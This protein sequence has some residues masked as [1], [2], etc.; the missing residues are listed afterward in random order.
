MRLA[1]EQQ[2]R[3]A[4]EQRVAEEEAREAE[5]MRVAAESKVNEAEQARLAEEKKIKDARQAL[6]DAREEEFT[7]EVLQPGLNG[8]E[9]AEVSRSATQL[10]SDENFP[11]LKD[12]MESMGKRFST[13]KNLHD[14]SAKILANT[15]YTGSL[16][17]K[18][19]AI[20][21]NKTFS[22]NDGNLQMSLGQGKAQIKWSQLHPDSYV[23]LLQ[24]SAGNMNGKMKTS[25]ERIIESLQKDF[26]GA[27]VN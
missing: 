27:R 3:E 6:V 7:K 10:S 9:F 18:T 25:A 19:V 26:A 12:K 16:K 23:K 24:F 8:L 1:K 20:W 2:N 15:N 13:Y 11:E 14:A 17:Q 21:T 5:E 22:V 4:E